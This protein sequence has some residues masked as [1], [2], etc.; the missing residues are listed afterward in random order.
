MYLG[1]QKAHDYIIGL[2]LDRANIRK[3]RVP[4]KFFSVFFVI[5]RRLCLFEIL[6]YIIY[7]VCII[8]SLLCFHDRQ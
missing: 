5:R 2:V 8:R 7:N 1:V 6:K 3:K 4:A